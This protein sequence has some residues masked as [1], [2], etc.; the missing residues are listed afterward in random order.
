MRYG[1]SV[2]NLNEKLDSFM[3]I[4]KFDGHKRDAAINLCYF[5]ILSLDASVV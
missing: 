4:Y 3:N 2:I 5:L 1:I